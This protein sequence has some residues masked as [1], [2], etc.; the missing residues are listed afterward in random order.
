MITKENQ[1][2]HCLR[3]KARNA[4]DCAKGYCSKWWAVRDK[5]AEEDCR[6]AK[7]YY[8]QYVQQ[9]VIKP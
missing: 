6:L 3:I 4:D 5:E 8:D 7:A 9:G 2:N 1:C